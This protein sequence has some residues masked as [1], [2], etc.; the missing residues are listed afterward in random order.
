MN[1][2]KY[3]RTDIAEN[4]EFYGGIR[5]NI[6]LTSGGWTNVKIGVDKNGRVAIMGCGDDYTDHYYPKFCPE[7]GRRLNEHRR[8]RP[9]LRR[10]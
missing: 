7:C 9:T 4:D 3:C 2:C 6:E 5:E 1:K 8:V 10:M